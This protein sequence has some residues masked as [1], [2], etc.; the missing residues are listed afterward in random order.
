MATIKSNY[1]NG[2][3]PMP[4]PVA[5]E[6]VSVRVLVSLLAAEVALNNVI[7]IGLL[8]ADCVPVGYVVAATDLDTNG[9]PT[10]ALDFG[11]LND[12][13]TAISVA[14]EDGG[15]EWI[16]GSTVAQAGGIVLSTASKAAYDVIGAVEAVDTDRIVAL[17]VATGAATAAAGSIEV[18]LFYKAA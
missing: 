2:K 6:V 18:E 16:D 5:Q 7:Q 4:I 13:G 17:V 9:T 10:L 12:A 14:A 8:P 1:A 11:L 15:D 3:T